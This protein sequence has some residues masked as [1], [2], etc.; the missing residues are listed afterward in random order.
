VRR[1]GRALLAACVLAAAPWVSAEPAAAPGAAPNVG[2]AL[3]GL[4]SQRT[5][6]LTTTGRRTGNPHT[7]TVW[8]LVDGPVLYL[9]T[10]DPTRDWV[11]N[12]LKQPEVRL[13]FG[14]T[15]LLG[16]LHPVTDPALE[17]HIRQALRDKYWIAWAGGLVGQG[18]KQ[19][20]LVDGLRPATP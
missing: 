10:L 19:T 5:V 7:V 12:V 3:A 2:A 20:F 4:R 14:G 17:T 6:E 13:D 1:F 18:P 16:Q 15:V 9:N 11:R 8:F